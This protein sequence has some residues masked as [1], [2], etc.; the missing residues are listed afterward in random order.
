MKT[1]QAF[2]T[3]DGQLFA[4]ENNAKLHEMFLEKEDVVEVFLKTKEN[5][6]QNGAQRVIAKRTII[7]WELWKIKNAG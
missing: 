2:L 5:P 3:D 6:Y 4:V 7:N 1:I